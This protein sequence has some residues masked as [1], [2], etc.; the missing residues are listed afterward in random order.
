MLVRESA[1]WPVQKVG[2]VTVDGDDDLA[3]TFCYNRQHLWRNLG[4]IFAFMNFSCWLYLLAAEYISDKRPKGKVLNV[5]KDST[6]TLPTSNS[7]LLVKRLLRKL[8]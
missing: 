8:I 1:L 4:L 2:S 7:N 5:V 6:K 3:I